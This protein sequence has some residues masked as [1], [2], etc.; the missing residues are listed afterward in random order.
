MYTSPATA[1]HPPL[2]QAPCKA[3]GVSLLGKADPA[4]VHPLPGVS[5]S[6]SAGPRSKSRSP[7]LLCHLAAPVETTASGCSQRVETVTQVAWGQATL[8]VTVSSFPMGLSVSLSH[9]SSPWPPKHCQAAGN[10]PETTEVRCLEA[11]VSTQAGGPL[12]FELRTHSH[13]IS[14]D[15]LG[16]PHPPYFLS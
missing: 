16:Q 8:A 13:A 2:P 15:S 7:V 3:G 1:I 12:S 14:S 4:R 11:R 9:I 5:L 6:A 10:L